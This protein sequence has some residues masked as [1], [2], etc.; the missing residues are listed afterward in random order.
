VGGKKAVPIGKG[1]Y[2]SRLALPDKKSAEVTPSKRGK[3]SHRSK[4]KPPAVEYAADT[5]NP[6]SGVPVVGIGASPCGLEALEIFSTHML[7]DA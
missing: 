3:L 4:S 2:V 5:G 6:V 1:Y 7:P